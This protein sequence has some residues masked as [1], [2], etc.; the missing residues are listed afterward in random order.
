M[1]RSGLILGIA[2]PA[3]LLTLLVHPMVRDNADLVVRPGLSIAHP[4]QDVV[5][6]RASSTTFLQVATVIRSERRPTEPA[7]APQRQ[8]SDRSSSKLP[9][10]LMKEGCEGAISSLAGPEAR[11]MLPGRCIA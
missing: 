10:R 3:A 7:T 9:R 11:R 1:L 2:G 6:A 8:N 5:M 4:F